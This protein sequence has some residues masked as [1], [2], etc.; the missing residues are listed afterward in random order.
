M[1]PWSAAA[2]AGLGAFGILQWLGRTYGATVREQRR[3]LPDDELVV[4]PRI[5]TTH[6]ITIDAR[7]AAVWPWLVQMGWHRGGWYTRHGD[8]HRAGPPPAPT[9]TIRPATRSTTRST[10]AATCGERPSPNRWS[11]ASM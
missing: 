6:A 1:R 9:R 8:L 11:W 3:R 5:V 7:P 10:A 2:V 4:E